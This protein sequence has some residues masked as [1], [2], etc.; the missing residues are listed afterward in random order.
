MQL[1]FDICIGLENKV[2]L[3]VSLYNKAS[4]TLWVVSL[5][6]VKLI[7]Y[8]YKETFNGEMMVFIQLFFKRRIALFYILSRFR[9]IIHF[10]YFEIWT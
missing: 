3:L 10:Y 6:I 4:C 9:F 5:E 8:N 7:R 2:S 1:I